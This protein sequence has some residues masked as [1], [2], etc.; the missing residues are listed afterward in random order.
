MIISAPKPAIFFQ[1]S[2]VFPIL[3]L[4]IITILGLLTNAFFPIEV[5]PLGIVTFVNLLPENAY[6][7]ISVR[8]SGNIILVNSLLSI[9]Y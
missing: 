3:E 8:L 1:I 2:F 9:V 5:T 6:S 4:L 7:Q